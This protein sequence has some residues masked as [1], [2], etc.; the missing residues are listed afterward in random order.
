MTL[1]PDQ[2]LRQWKDVIQDDSGCDERSCAIFLPL[3]SEHSLLGYKEACRI[4]AHL[5][6]DKDTGH[7]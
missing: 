5:I 1:E 4:L 2:D 3:I 7:R 6:K